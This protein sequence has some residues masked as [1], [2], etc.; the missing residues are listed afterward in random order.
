[1]EQLPGCVAPGGRSWK[2]AVDSDRE[3][4]A[5]EYLFREA[6][7]ICDKNAERRFATKMFGNVTVTPVGRRTRSGVAIPVAKVEVPKYIQ[8][9]LF[10]LT[11]Q[12]ELINALENAGPRRSP[13]NKGQPV[14]E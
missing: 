13:R 4:A 2:E 10:S 8:P 9:K 1:V 14:K 3:Y 6:L 12:R 7:N 11:G 5:T